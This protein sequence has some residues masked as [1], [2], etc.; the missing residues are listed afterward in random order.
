MRFKLND[1]A[2]NEAIKIIR[3]WTNLNQ[4]DF[5]KSIHRTARTIQAWESGETSFNIEMLSNIA[6]KH[7]IEIIFQK[8]EK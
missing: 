1:Y 6:K 7:G 3:E 5:G 8:N 2:P 4:T